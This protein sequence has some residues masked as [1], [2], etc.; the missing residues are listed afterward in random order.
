MNNI[1]LYITLIP[2][3]IQDLIWSE[4]GLYGQRANNN[5]PEVK[6]PRKLSTNRQGHIVKGVLALFS[7]FFAVRSLRN[8]QKFTFVQEEL[9]SSLQG[10]ISAS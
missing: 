1:Q 4:S 8:G 9:Y 2:S 3:G 10:E 7:Y 5:A 6:N